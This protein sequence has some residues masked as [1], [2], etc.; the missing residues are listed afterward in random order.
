MPHKPGLLFLCHRIPIPPNKGDK[1]R[2]FNILKYLSKH[3]DIYFAGFVDD[4]AD[5]SSVSQLSEFCVD[6]IVEKQNKTLC[7]IKS[8]TGFVTGKPLTLPFYASTK[9]QTWVNNR[10]ADHGIEKVF[11]YSAAMGQFVFGKRSVKGNIVMDFVDVDSDKWQQY[12]ESKPGLMSLIY[13]REARQLAAYEYFIK[14]H[15]HHCC[16]VSEQEAN[17]FD[18]MFQQKSNHQQRSFKKSVGLKNGVDTDYFDPELVFEKPDTMRDTKTIVFTGAMD[19]WPNVS[20]ILW[21][22]ENVFTLIQSKYTT[23]N[24]LVVGSKP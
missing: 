3:F 23:V 21:F 15:A 4:A 7:K 9:I 18:D 17:F 5:Y 2:S 13:Q 11:I 1:I 24:L 8:L 19:Y 22:V 20:A 14:E 16:F 12:V 6:Y 10:I